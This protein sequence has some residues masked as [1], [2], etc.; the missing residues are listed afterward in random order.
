MTKILMEGRPFPASPFYTAIISSPKENRCLPDESSDLA[1]NK[2]M[3]DKWLPKSHKAII[4][5]KKDEPHAHKQGSS[6]RF[7]TPKENYLQHQ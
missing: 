5:K 2:W 7:F 1:R 6:F 3:G 4:F